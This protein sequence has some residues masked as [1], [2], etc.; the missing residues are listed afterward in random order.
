VIQDG[1]VFDGNCKMEAKSHHESEPES[2][3][4]LVE[5][6]YAEISSHH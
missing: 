3:A 5:K 6:S 4:I 1:G 2:A